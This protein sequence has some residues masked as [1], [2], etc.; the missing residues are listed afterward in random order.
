[1]TKK[2]KFYHLWDFKNV[3]GGII[4]ILLVSALLF[5][6]FFYPKI[7]D[8]KRL[9]GFDAQTKGQ[10]IKYQPVETIKQTKLGT[11]VVIDEYKITYSYAVDGQ[12]YNRTESIECLSKYASILKK[13][14][15]TKN[16]ITILYMSTEPANS[17]VDLE[18]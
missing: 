14:R 8:D 4:V 10:L 1:M 2:V 17:T 18:N 9:S 15:S 5:F 12:I 7:A 16:P 3:I 6:T 11:E 13:L